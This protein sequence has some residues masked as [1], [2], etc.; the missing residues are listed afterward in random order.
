MTG[1]GG[2]A[3]AAGLAVAAASAF[4]IGPGFVPLRAAAR[5]LAVSFGPPALAEPA[6]GL[7]AGFFSTGF[8]S[9]GCAADFSAGSFAAGAEAASPFRARAI[10]SI[11]ATLGL[12]AAAAAAAAAGFAAGFGL[13]AGAGTAAAGSLAGVSLAGASSAGGAASAGFDSAAPAALPRAM[14]RISAVVSFFFSAIE[15]HSVRLTNRAA[16]R[17]VRVQG[18]ASPPRVQ[19]ERKS[20][21][22][23]GLRPEIGC[24]RRRRE[25]PCD[26]FHKVVPLI[27]SPSARI[28]NHPRSRLIA[29]ATAR[30]PCRP[31]EAADSNTLRDDCESHHAAI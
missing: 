27:C 7:S 9:A 16:R 18:P 21:Q 25:Q 12:P 28:V 8:F 4:V 10:A 22:Q 31:F 15:I 20:L 6:A 19:N 1:I 2:F 23:G 5:I 24:G 3:F 13:A 26:F 17:I 30:R 14:A 29:A 11:S